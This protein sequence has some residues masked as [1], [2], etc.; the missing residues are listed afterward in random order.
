M[1]LDNTRPTSLEGELDGGQAENT[2]GVNNRVR[3]AIGGTVGGFK[4]LE[5]GK[6]YYLA[7]SA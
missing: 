5:V 7:D 2:E 6:R 3:V 1:S 4:D